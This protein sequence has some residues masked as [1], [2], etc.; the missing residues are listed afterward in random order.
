M[1]AAQNAGAV[2]LIM[3]NNGLCADEPTADPDECTILW[4]ADPGIGYLYDIRP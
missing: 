2:G 1:D 4:G 3:V